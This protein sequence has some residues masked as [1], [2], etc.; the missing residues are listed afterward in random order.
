MC[1]STGHTNDFY[2]MKYWPLMKE[3]IRRLE[4]SEMHLII[5]R[6]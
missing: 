2:G 3:E 6:V 4:V 5:V 1:R